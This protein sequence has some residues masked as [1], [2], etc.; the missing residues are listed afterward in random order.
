[1][2][3]EE[4]M[5]EEMPENNV[6]MEVEANQPVVY[7]DDL[8]YLTLKGFENDKV[9]ICKQAL[10]TCTNVLLG[11]HVFDPKLFERCVEEIRVRFQYHL[12]I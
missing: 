6:N 7:C 5:D 12:L 3:K 2:V 10:S 8:L 11:A 1:M 4:P 9:A